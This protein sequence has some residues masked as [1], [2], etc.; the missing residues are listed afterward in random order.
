MSGHDDLLNGIQA[1]RELGFDDPRA[2][3]ALQSAIDSGDLDAEGN[4]IAYFELGRCWHGTGKQDKAQEALEQA[5]ALGTDPK[6]LAL[7]HHELGETYFVLEQESEAEKHFR[8]SLAQDRQH[9]FAPDT[10]IL[11]ARI[12]Y[13]RTEHDDNLSLLEESYG[14]SDEALVL[15][16]GPDSE[17]YGDFF[18]RPKALFD[19][20]FGK[21]LC[22]SDMPRD[23][24]RLEAVPNFERAE[25]IALEHPDSITRTELE[26][27]YKCWA[28][29][30]NRMGLERDVELVADRATRNLG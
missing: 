18:S 23:K 25:Q 30:L 21:A 7:A 12:V 22:K 24:E 3:K 15:L 1:I 20:Y 29:M 27:T 26:N 10:L 4:A 9:T 5:I 19:C 13:L 11:L 14:F 2:H 6:L 8:Q 16:E 28:G 17:Q